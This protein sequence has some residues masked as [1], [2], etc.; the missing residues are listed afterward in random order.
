MEDKIKHKKEV[1]KFNTEVLKQLYPKYL[2][3]IEENIKNNS[4]Q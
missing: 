2:K 1:K 3:L 4:T